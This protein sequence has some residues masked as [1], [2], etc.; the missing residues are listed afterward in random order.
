MC[1]KLAILISAFLLPFLAIARGLAAEP[2]R[3]ILL[4]DGFVL[5]AVEGELVRP[6]P[7]ETTDSAS[8]SLLPADDRWFFEFDSEV[9]GDRGSL[10]A[11]TRLRLLPS[12][13]LEQM[14]ADANERPV[15]SYRLWARVTKYRGENFIFPSYFL[16]LRKIKE[17]GPAQS[18]AKPE[19]TI[20]DSNDVLVVPSQIKE[21]LKTGRAA[22][23][24]QPEDQKITGAGQKR[25]KQ[26]FIL[27]NRIGLI[28]QSQQ[29][30]SFVL[31]ALG[32]N[33][34]PA[35]RGFRL[36]PCQPL[37]LAERKQATEP[38]PIRLKVAGIVTEYK[39]NK[40]L[41]LQRATQ[42]YSYGN[43]DY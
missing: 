11:G 37:E 43:F 4:R 24:R 10:K 33:V 17:P 29:R 9:K 3:R 26:N 35:G 32:R 16:P 12:A 28:R 15:R 5:R 41:L 21:M 38:D 36:L 27:A 23:G 34:Q 6:D 8:I 14:I 22:P 20:D 39:G 40:Y 2:A 30:V 42:V 31:D 18:E 25:V 19:P 13:T 7:N 1:K